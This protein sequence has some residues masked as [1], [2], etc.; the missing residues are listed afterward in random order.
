[1]NVMQSHVPLLLQC[2]GLQCMADVRLHAGPAE[3]VGL[4]EPHHSGTATTSF[5]SATRMLKTKRGGGGSFDHWTITQRH[6]Q[7][8]L[9]C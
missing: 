1:M 7:D 3:F 9:C 2:V 4:A 6:T 8:K 5:C